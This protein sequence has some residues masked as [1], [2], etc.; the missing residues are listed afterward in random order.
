MPLFFQQ[1][2]NEDA[3]LGIWSIS[4]EES[5][6][7]QRVQHLPSM[8]HPLN[9]KR[10]LAGR[11][12]LTV[13]HP[14]FPLVDIKIAATR[15]PYLPNDPVHFSITHAGDYAAAIVSHSNKVGVDLEIYTPRVMKVVH[16][17]LSE[18]ERK[19]LTA[20]TEAP[21]VMETILWSVK[22]SVYKWYGSGSLDFI[23]HMQIRRIQKIDE[24]HF[25]IHTFCKEEELLVYATCFSTF[26]LTWV[27]S[28]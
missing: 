11:Y 20:C 26:C 17:F 13:L 23:K 7:Q 19:L 5:Y 14:A 18:E 4:E 25:H 6:F 1:N 16:K 10:H 8:A 3:L 27:L 9:R 12:L 22:E 28:K 24:Q 2:I 15:K 21:Y